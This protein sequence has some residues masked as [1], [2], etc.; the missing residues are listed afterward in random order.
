MGLTATKPFVPVDL[1]SPKRGLTVILS[2]DRHQHFPDGRSVLIERDRKLKFKDGRCQVT[3]PADYELLVEHPAFTGGAEPKVVF[4]MSDSPTMPKAPDGV[5][6]VSGAIS[7][8]TGARVAEPIPGY[9]KMQYAALRRA[10]QAGKVEDY[11]Q[12]MTYERSF[13]N[14]R[15][16]IE[17]FAAAIVAAALPDPSSMVAADEKQ[18]AEQDAKDGIDMANPGDA[19]AAV[20]ADEGMAAAL[21][22]AEAADAIEAEQSVAIPPE[23]VL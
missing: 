3:D 13:R 14:R 11:V 12:A 16:V 18:K 1:V 4:L 19:G 8:G 9:D 20:G 17:L 21:A 6:V 5:R 22:A 2:A 15:G 7:S 23:G 10:V